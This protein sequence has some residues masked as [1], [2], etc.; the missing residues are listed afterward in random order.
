MF[1]LYFIKSVQNVSFI[2]LRRHE[3]VY[4]IHIEVYKTDLFIIGLI[5][6]MSIFWGTNFVA[7]IKREKTF[8]LF[9]NLE[10][11]KKCRFS[12]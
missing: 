9:G 11:V 5:T 10:F 1:H 3:W 8:Y 12:T 7:M 4:K 2:K 6:M